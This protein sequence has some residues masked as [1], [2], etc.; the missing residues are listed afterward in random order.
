VAD[1][2]EQLSALTDRV[3]RLEERHHGSAIQREQDRSYLDLH[4]AEIRSMIAV[5]MAKVRTALWVIG[6]VW[7]VLVVVVGFWLRAR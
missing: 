3:E 4:V 6:G 5:E 1:C 2:A 7:G